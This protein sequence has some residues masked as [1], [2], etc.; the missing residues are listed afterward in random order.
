MLAHNG[1][2]NQVSD[3]NLGVPASY[4][5]VGPFAKAIW[6]PAHGKPEQKQAHKG[7][8]PLNIPNEENLRPIPSGNQPAI[9]KSCHP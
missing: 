2:H 5:A 8:K 3:M 9:E 7:L 6:F 4:L 1:L